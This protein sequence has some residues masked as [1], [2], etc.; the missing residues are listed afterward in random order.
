MKDKI[1]NILGGSI[2]I[3]VEGKNINNFIHRLIKNN[4]NIEKVIPIS[5]KEAHLIVD[6]R[7]LVKIQKIKTIYKVKVIKYYG[8]LRL[9]K[10]T[11]RDIFL[12]LSLLVGVLTIYIL[13]NMI[14]K[15]EVIHSNKSIIK[16][17]NE[18][19]YSNGI[20]KYHFVK[21]YSEI[22]KIKKK[23]LEDNKDSIEWLEI[24]REG[25]KYTVRVEERI[26]NKKEDSDK[27]YDIVA[28]KNAVIK[29]IVANSGEKVKNI[30]TYVKKGETIISSQITLPNSTTIEKSA[31]GTITGEVWYTVRVEYPY[32]YNE[33]LY[34]GNKKKVLVFNLLNK[35]ISFFD[36]HK[37]KTFER[38]IKYIFNNNFIPFSLTYEDEYETKI[39]ND[40][41]TKETAS[42]KA[43]EVAKE[44]L[45]DKYS[46]IIDVID[47]KIINEEETSTKIVLDLFITCLEDI[48]KYKEVLE[49]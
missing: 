45:L 19:L 16:L 37:Y 34:T 36:F 29:T 31:S 21:S 48:T 14:F 24:I 40:I 27:I 35:R 43:I 7:E 38:N 30:N 13:S 42:K 47:I 6:Y 8:R 25:T 9:L 33:T 2:K 18:E 49:E 22:E 41:Y 23:I 3:K 11:K 26:I 17:V 15:I 4:I 28:S 12:L 44:K 1:L 5:Y 39:I 10:R 32:F 46:T 20:R